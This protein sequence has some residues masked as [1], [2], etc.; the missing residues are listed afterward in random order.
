MAS[1]LRPLVDADRELLFRWINDRELVVL[2]APFHPVSAAEHAAW[3]GG[4]RSARDVKIFAIGDP[5]TSRTIGYCQLKRID[6]SNG[7][8]E[9]QIRIGERAMHGK[10][11]GTIAVK[12]LVDFGFGQL[13]LHRIYLHVFQDN[14]RAYRSYL[15]CGFR[16]EGVLKEAVR[17]EGVFK[18]VLVMAVV[19]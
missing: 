2:N 10:G 12:E 19:R 18:D 14:A 3:F 9:L 6:M 5:A 1:I 4:V 16:L 17:I 7:N 8:A 11:L 13:G 15:K